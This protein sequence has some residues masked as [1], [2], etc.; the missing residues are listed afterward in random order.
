MIFIQKVPGQV[1]TSP[2]RLTDHFC[3]SRC[4]WTWS[5]SLIF[6]DIV[7]KV[8]SDSGFLKEC[9]GTLECYLKFKIFLFYA[10]A[11]DQLVVT[12]IGQL[13]EESSSTQIK[14]SLSGSMKKIIFVWFLCKKEETLKKSTADL[15]L[16]VDS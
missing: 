14:L 8:L 2:Y 13:V 1:R 3:K 4:P 11:W 5:I 10:V 9:I 7:L 15:L 12:M 6:I 16:Y